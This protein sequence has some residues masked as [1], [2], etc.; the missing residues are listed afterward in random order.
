MSG[1]KAVAEAADPVARLRNLDACAVSDALDALGLLGAALG[2]H[3]VTGQHRLAGRTVTIDLA[4]AD[5]VTSPRHLGTAAID[6]SGAGDVIVV[7][8]HGRRHVSGWGGVLSTGAWQAGV[9][10]VV[11]DGAV[12]DVDEAADL[13]LP[14]F[15]ATGV[16]VTARG[17]VAERA[18]NVE[19][20]VAGVRVSPGDYVVADGSGVVFVPASEIDAVLVRA[21]VV[22][23]EERA[24][25]A[26]VR[27]G[28]PMTEIMGA[29]YENLLTRG[30]KDGGR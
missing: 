16:P 21:E 30:V 5:A 13:G 1:N 7:A 18:W 23:A 27:A 8:H 22:A 25:I 12:R 19:V 6:A 26:K 2:L 24:M 28:R 20:E 10:G 29:D 14:V 3:S 4:E 17:R 9:E 15:A 11:V